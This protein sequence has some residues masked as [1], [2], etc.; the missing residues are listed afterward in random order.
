MNT[1]QFVQPYRTVGS[2]QAFGQIRPPGP[3][4]VNCCQVTRSPSY[5]PIIHSG[6]STQDSAFILITFHVVS[7][8]Q[9]LQHVKIILN[10]D[11][12]NILYLISIPSRVVSLAHLISI[13]TTTP[14]CKTW[15][16]MWPKTSTREQ[17]NVSIAEAPAHLNAPTNHLGSDCLGTFKFTE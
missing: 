3:F 13:P 6:T 1:A 9:A 2:N 4:Y 15:I 10:L 16:K 7:L 8:G 14:S 5:I 12:V 11:S 17:S